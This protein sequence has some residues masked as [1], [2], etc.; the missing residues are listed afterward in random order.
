MCL[1][2]SLLIAC[3]QESPPAAKTGQTEE[4]TPSSAQSPTGAQSARTEP[5]GVDA[6]DDPGRPRAL[7]K[8]GEVGGWVKNKP[9]RV[10]PIERA[11]ELLGDSPINR[12]LSGFRLTRVAGCG[13]QN[14]VMQ[15]DVLLIEARTAMDAFGF[16][17]M[18]CGGG[19]YEMAADGSIRRIAKAENPGLWQAWQGQTFVE[20]R[21][22]GE[23]GSAD[24]VSALLQRILFNTPFADAPVLPRVV[25]PELRKS[26]RLWLVRNASTLQAI[27]HPALRLIQASAIDERLGLTGDVFLSLAAMPSTHDEPENLVWLVE[28][29]NDVAAAAAYSRYQKAIET[30]VAP[31]DATTLIEELKG[32]RL[33]GSWTAEIESVQKVLPQLRRA[34]SD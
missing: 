8:T 13:Y 28:Y 31:P 17:S 26:A 7:P 29:P 23:P 30:A 22:S 10:L 33:I 32:P 3:R 11:G 20:V 4:T 21:I 6:Q 27:E 1:A 19:P 18:A 2:V 34:L 24:A 12:F 14:G 5:R 25:P 16:F 15:A 9:V